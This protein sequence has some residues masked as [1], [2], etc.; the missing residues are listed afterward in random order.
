MKKQAT[1]TIGGSTH[2]RDLHATL[3]RFKWPALTAATLAFALSIG[4]CAAEAQAKPGAAS[5]SAQ[6]QNVNVVNTPSVNVANTPSVSVA[7]TPTVNVANTPSVTVSGTPSVN[8]TVTNTSTNPV[9]SVD[10]E[11]MSRIP[12]QSSAQPTGFCNSGIL[13]CSFVFTAPPA[14]YRLVVENVSG[15]L[16]LTPDAT[17]PFAVLSE[18]DGFGTSYWSFTGSLGLS[19]AAAVQASFNAPIRAVFDSAPT[20]TVTASWTNVGKYMT[21]SGYLENCAVTGCPFIVH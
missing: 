18:N 13:S 1:H 11:K 21:L 2:A 14:G 16:T 9:Q 7:N 12:Y 19:T 10:A 3:W 6:T 8:A 20:M 15:W 4:A 17:T 5:A